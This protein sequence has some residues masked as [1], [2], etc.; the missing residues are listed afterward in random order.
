MEFKQTVYLHKKMPR[1][2]ICI[3]INQIRPAYRKGEAMHL[4]MIEVTRDWKFDHIV[5]ICKGE[6]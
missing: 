5:S 6:T 4:I 3:L 2:S 1:Q